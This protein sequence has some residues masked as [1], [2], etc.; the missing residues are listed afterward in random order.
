MNQ[1]LNWLERKF[2]RYGI[3]D[4]MLYV[5]STMLVLYLFQNVLRV[6]NVTGLFA[7]VPSLVLRGQVW[8]LITFVFLPPASS[9]LTVLLALY[10]YYFIGS[11]LENYWGTFRFNVYYLCGI[12]GTI[13]AAFLTG[14]ATNDYLN[15]SLFFA[16]AALFPEQ[17]VLLFFV[18]PMKIK[19]LAYLDA[20]YFLLGFVFG[21]WSV[22][23]AII[24][25]LINFFL[26]FGPD[27][28]RRQ[29][30]RQRFRATQENFRRQ[31]NNNNRQGW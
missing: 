18:I 16:F 12:L 30:D 17:E 1:W 19:Y 24:A 27:F 5:T 15:L 13:V 20:A 11:S 21:S 3:P 28:L 14:Y 23:A 2:G 31:M 9:M 7:L 26:F 29:R 10:F 4:V 25:S 22:R 6:F 8:R